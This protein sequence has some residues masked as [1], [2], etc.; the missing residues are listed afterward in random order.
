MRVNIIPDVEK[1]PVDAIASLFRMLS[2]APRVRILLAIGAEEVC[3]CHLEAHLG[4]RQAYLSQQLMTLREAR[5]V[6]SR[7]DGRNIFYHLEN[8]GILDLIY[9]SGEMFGLSVEEVKL[10]TQ[11]C[12]HPSC[13]C[14]SCKKDEER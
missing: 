8:P 4:Y 13:S 12:S 6:A 5:L 14:P 3:V 11:F 10:S 2:Q 1:E 9:R 7:R